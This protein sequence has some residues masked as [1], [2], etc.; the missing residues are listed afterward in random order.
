[1]TPFIEAA[2]ELGKRAAADR[3]DGEADDPD[4]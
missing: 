3:R 2:A 1:M 4:G